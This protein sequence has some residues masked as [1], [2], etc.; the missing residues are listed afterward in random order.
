MCILKWF[1]VQTHEEKLSLELK[2]KLLKLSSAVNS[3]PG[4]GHDAA[5][6]LDRQNSLCPQELPIPLFCS[7]QLSVGSAKSG[8]K[9]T[10]KEERLIFLQVSAC[11]Q[12]LLYVCPGGRTGQ[13]TLAGSAG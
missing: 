9:S 11:V 12:A 2:R 8:R 7:E 1:H 3:S 4:S 6:C 10:S 13:S 5:G